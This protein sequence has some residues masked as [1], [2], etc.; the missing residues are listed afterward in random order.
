MRRAALFL[1]LSASA[2]ATAQTVGP[3]GS[4]PT[5]GNGIVVSGN[6]VSTGVYSRLNLSTSDTILAGDGGGVVYECNAS[7]T[8]VTLPS[9][10][11]TGFGYH[12]GTV[13]VNAQT[14]PGQ[15]CGGTVTVTSAST[16]AGS[17]S[18]AL[19]L[20]PG[21]GAE[22]DTDPTSIF[23]N[24]LLCT[25][26]NCG[27]SGGG[28]VTSVGL[29]LPA[30]FTVSG[31]PVTASGNLTGTLATQSANTVFAGPSSGSAA[32]PT[33]RALVAADL[34]SGIVFKS[35]NYYTSGATWTK[36]AGAFICHIQG[37]GGTGGGGGGSDEPT[38]TL[39]LGG[40]GGGGAPK[41]DEWRL[42]ADLSSPASVTIGAAGVGG[43]GAASIGVGG[44]G[45]AGGLTSLG[46]QFNAFGGGGGAGGQLATDS[47]G[48]GSGGYTAVGGSSTSATA[49][50]AGKWGG[51][52]GGAVG[53]GNDATGF[54]TAGSGGGAFSGNGG[55]GG[56][57]YSGGGGAGGSNATAGSASAGGGGG[58]SESKAGGT[59]GA[60]TG[61]NGNPGTTVATTD[62]FSGGGGGGANQGGAGGNGAVPSGGGG[63]GTTAG[64]N[65]GNGVPGWLAVDCL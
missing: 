9:V 62:G 5:A 53:N 15:T 30:I 1:A 41:T 39:G 37:Q 59:G 57:G 27:V 2:L 33:F 25:S 6:T 32:A 44:N 63:A 47:G 51:Q 28:G 29:S 64:G 12:F 45:T 48:G 56:A 43:T 22:V 61:A 42:A 65:G 50:I 24:V 4:A 17:L 13:I 3:P 38:L 21:Q 52:A 60:A 20:A 55:F 58:A 54:L 18:G 34:A 26:S 11:T 23:F 19:T 14:V 46:N 7:A 35:S 49:G 31:S 8:A 10:G 36:P 16:L 40:G